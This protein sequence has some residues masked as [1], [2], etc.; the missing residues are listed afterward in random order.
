LQGEANADPDLTKQEGAE[1]NN[2]RKLG[3]REEEN[4]LETHW[5]R[6]LPCIFPKI[7]VIQFMYTLF[8]SKGNFQLHTVTRT[9]QKHLILYYG[10]RK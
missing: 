6:N 4:R 10:I 5:T 7:Y 9:V 1:S 3:P 2:S 8:F